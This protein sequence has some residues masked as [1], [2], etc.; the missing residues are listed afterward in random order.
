[1]CENRKVK[2]GV[3]NRKQRSGT[4]ALLPRG[5]K[6]RRRAEY[7]GGTAIGIFAALILLAFAS[8]GLQ[9]LA[10]SSPQLA[11]VVSSILVD[12]TNGDRAVSGLGILTVNPALVA[13]AQAKAND[14]AEHGYFAHVSPAGI[15]PWHWFKGAGYAFEYAGENLAIDF[16]DSADVER[17]WMNSPTHRKNI[18]DP[19]YTEIGIATAQGMYQGRLTTFVVQEFGAPAASSEQR[20]VQQEVPEAPTTLATAAA[21]PAPESDESQV[22]GS[23]A[24]ETT[25]ATP[26]LEPVRAAETGSGAIA[27]TEPALAASLAIDAG[28]TPWWGYMLAYPRETLRWAYYLI[29]ALILVALA[30]ETGF[31]IR[32]HHARHALV[33][34]TMLGVMCLLFI[35]ADYLFFAEPV[36]AAGW[37]G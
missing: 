16:A 2:R 19:H 5:K 17:A 25:P 18:L 28:A 14:M 4:G 11:A 29:G 12:L 32:W 1:M 13:A 35:M 7:L 31:E 10:L 20:I 21:K 9:R 30:L 15:D 24:D 33:A 34:G 23:V 8:S 22:L 26:A 37:L 6:A 3:R 27:T 36:L